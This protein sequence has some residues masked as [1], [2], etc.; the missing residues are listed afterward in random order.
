M[1]N[2]GKNQIDIK[3]LPDF[4]RNSKQNGSEFGSPVVSTG[5][6]IVDPPSY[7]IAK[8]SIVVTM[9]VVLFV[10]GMMVYQNASMQ[11]MTVVVDVNAGD[12][13]TITKL[14]SDSGAKVISV[15]QKEDKVY[16]VKLSTHKSKKTLLNILLKDKNVKN[17]ELE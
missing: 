9:T 12:K 8:M 6:I 10:G 14:M 17:A 4:I 1:E 13:D 15:Q 11:D 2:N 7:W 5:Q 16:E 3:D